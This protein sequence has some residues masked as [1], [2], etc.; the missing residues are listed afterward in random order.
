MALTQLTTTKLTQFAYTNTRFVLVIDKKCPFCE[1]K[2]LIIEH[3]E[4]YIYFV[5][6]NQCG[7]RGPSCANPEHAATAWNDQPKTIKLD[8]I[9]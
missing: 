7:A 5:Q 1:S 4:Y 8:Q 6:C 9:E 3:D 2:K